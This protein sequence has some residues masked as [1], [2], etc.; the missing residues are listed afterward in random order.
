MERILIV[1]DDTSIRRLISYSL[2][3]EGYDIMEAENG[4][5]ALKIL[6]R[7]TADLIISDIMMP[8][9]DGREL[10]RRVR[11]RPE[12]KTVPFIF[13][14]VKNQLADKIEGLSIGGD[15]YIISGLGFDEIITKEGW[16]ND[17]VEDF[18]Q[19]FDKIVIYASNIRWSQL[20]VTVINVGGDPEIDDTLVAWRAGNKTAS[21]TLLDFVGLLETDFDF[22]Q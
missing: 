6:L 17:T 22:D 3:K 16:G 14:T 11:E 9:M 2:M 18:A 7:N 10:C 21:V 15:D 5:E 12:L 8:E 20:T 4:K 19:S 1:E 13:L